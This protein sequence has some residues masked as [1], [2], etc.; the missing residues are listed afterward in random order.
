MMEKCCF[1][2]KWFD[3]E[4]SRIESGI[5]A[6]SYDG[7]LFC[8]LHIIQCRASNLWYMDKDYCSRF[9]EKEKE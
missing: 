8:R 9:E 5:G 7:R 4:D 2:C 3:G 1:N 6:G